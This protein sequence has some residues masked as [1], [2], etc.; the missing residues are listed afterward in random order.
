[1]AAVVGAAADALVGLALDGTILSWNPAAERLFSWPA[2]AALGQSIAVTVPADRHEEYVRYAERVHAGETITLETVRLARDGRRLEVRW[3]VAPI[4]GAD[5]RVVGRAAT[6]VYL[7]EQRRRTVERPAP[8][9]EREADAAARRERQRRLEQVERADAV[10]RLA[11]GVA[12]QFDA[13]LTALLGHAEGARQALDAGHPAREELARLEADGERGRALVEQLRAFGRRQALRPQRVDL[14][15][16]V[17]ERCVTLFTALLGPGVALHAWAAPDPP[18][19]LA[20]LVDTAQLD[21]AL[22]HLALNAREAM[23]GPDGAARGACELAV[24]ALALDEAAAA[25]WAPLAPGDY[26]RLRVRDTGRGMDDETRRRAFEP[27]YTTRPAGEGAGLGLPTVEGIVA[28]AG[29]A[30]RVESAPGA[31]CCVTLLLPAAA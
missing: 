3:T 21:Q 28:Q 1:L 7:G 8:A 2:E 12:H 25:A 15:A 30:V 24:D 19:P 6:F 13:L 11:E 10:G 18:H 14:A 17:L 27:F 26:V 9:A 31:G 22:L 29:G 4:L 16:H 5:G 23:R 20:A